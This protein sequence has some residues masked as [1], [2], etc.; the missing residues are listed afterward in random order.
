MLEAGGPKPALLLAGISGKIESE[1]SSPSP[2]P[3][4]IRIAHDDDDVAKFG[5]GDDAL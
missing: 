1:T 5:L 4:R 3:I 2:N